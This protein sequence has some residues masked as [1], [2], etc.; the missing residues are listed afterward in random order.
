MLVTGVNLSSRGSAASTSRGTEEVRRCGLSFRRA[1]HRL[2]AASLQTVSRMGNVA[3][4]PESFV[5]GVRLSS[6]LGEPIMNNCQ[7]MEEAFTG[8]TSRSE[9]HRKN[10]LT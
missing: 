8:C 6:L 1:R 5:E 2:L 10:M 7:G 3:D 9:S 4:L